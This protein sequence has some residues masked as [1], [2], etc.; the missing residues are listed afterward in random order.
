MS[1]SMIDAGAHRQGPRRTRAR[2]SARLHNTTCIH[3]HA[4][5]CRCHFALACFFGTL[6]WCLS[7]AP[8]SCLVVCMLAVLSHI[9]VAPVIFPSL[10]R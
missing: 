2:T 4:Y 3:A 7:G 9:L 10:R 8:A 1:R 5:G 6:L